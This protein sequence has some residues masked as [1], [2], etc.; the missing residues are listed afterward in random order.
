MATS[1]QEVTPD[2]SQMKRV[3]FTQHKEKHSKG[4]KTNQ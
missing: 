2:F 4:A 1:K 3:Y